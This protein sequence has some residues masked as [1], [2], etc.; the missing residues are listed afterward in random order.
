MYLVFDR[1]LRHFSPLSRPSFALTFCFYLIQILPTTNVFAISPDRYHSYETISQYMSEVA[2]KYDHVEEILLGHS[3]EGRP[4]RYLEMTTAQDPNAP[5]VYLNSTHHGNEKA[6]TIAILGVIDY[7]TRNFQQGEPQYFLSKY[8]LIIQP[9]VNPDGY[10]KGSRFAKGGI[11]PNRDYPHPRNQGKTF[12][13]EET[14]LVARLLATKNVAGSISF[15]AGIEAVLWPWCFA[16]QHTPHEK[17]FSFLGKTVANTMDIKRYVQSYMDYKSE[18]EFIDYAYMKYGTLALTVEVSKRAKPL[19]RYL[20]AIANNTIKGVLAYLIGLDG[21]LENNKPARN[22]V[23]QA[24]T[25]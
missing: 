15:H 13:L 10:V 18:G 3:G 5:A 23:A 17:H 24:I 19:R 6:A 1:M 21:I 25:H 9:F 14:R 12:Q 8:R 7:F 16:G 2:E 11:D 22:R 4:I 20:P